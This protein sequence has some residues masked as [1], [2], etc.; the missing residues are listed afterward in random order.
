MHYT[1]VEKLR[2]YF[3]TKY[4]GSKCHKVISKA[5]MSATPFRINSTEYNSGQ[6]IITIK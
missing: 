2:E 6:L 5:D 3:N 1:Q 4:E